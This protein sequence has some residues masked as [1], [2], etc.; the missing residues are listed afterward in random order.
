VC[1]IGIERFESAY[2][3]FFINRGGD[4]ELLENNAVWQIIVFSR[5][6]KVNFFLDIAGSSAAKTK[7][8][9]PGDQGGDF[10]LNRFGAAKVLQSE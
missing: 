5:F 2:H 1:E 9:L 10:C 3:L 4:G 8:R 7:N 6:N